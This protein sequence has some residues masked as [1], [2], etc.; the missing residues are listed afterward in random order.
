MCK[1]TRLILFFLINLCCTLEVFSAPEYF[2]QRVDYNI[3]V[4]LINDLNRLEGQQ[5]LT[6]FNHS[7]DTLDL[8]YFHLYL[9]K[10]KQKPPT[11]RQYG[12]QEIIHIMTSDEES[13]SYEIDRTIM[14]VGLISPLLPGDSV[15]IQIRFNALL[16]EASD[17]LGYYGDHFDI[18]NWYPVPAV[19]DCF[20]W[21]ADQH[22]DGEFYQEWGNYYVEITV[23]E[24]YIVG[25]TG[26]L[27]NKEVLPDSIDSEYREN[28]YGYNSD[29]AWVTYHFQ[30][31]NVHDFAWT[32]DPA[33]VYREIDVDGVMLKFL[34]LPYQLESWEPQIEIAAAAIRLFQEKI[35]PYPY[36]NMTVVD[37]YITAGGIEYP[38]FVII[39][40]V[41]S[42]ST[43]LS[44]T[45]IHEIA[46]QWFYGILGNNQTSYGWMDEGFAT[47]FEN[48]AM[49]ELNLYKN[50]YQ[51]SPPG[52]WGRFFGYHYNGERT[53]RLIYLRYIR[54]GQEEPINRHFDWFQNDP[55]VPF[56]QKMGLVASQLQLVLGDTIFW[57]GMNNYYENWKFR[58]P[59]PQDLIKSFEVSSQRELSWFFDQWVNTTWHCDYAVLG[60]RGKWEQRDSTHNFHATLHFKRNDPIVMPIDFRVYLKDGT[61]QDHR[62]PVHAGTA[63]RQENI[64]NLLPWDFKESEY[65]VEMEFP[66]EISD[67]QIDPDNRLLDINPFNNSTR[68][69]PKIYWSFLDRQYLYPYDDGYSA[70]IFPFIF[71]N[72]IDGAQIGARTQGN[73]LYSDYQHRSRIMLG[74]KSFQPEID[75]WFEHPLYSMQKDIHLVANIYHMTGIIGTGGWLQR[76]STEDGRLS[77]IILGWQWRQYFKDVYPPFPV[78]KGDISYIEFGYQYG[79]W[80]SGFLPVGA[81]F[82]LEAESSFLGSDYAY[83]HWEAGGMA[84][85]PAFFHQ[86]FSLNFRTGGFSGSVPVQKAF[87]V[88]GSSSYDY[89]YNPFLRAQGTLPEMWWSRGNVFNPGGGNLR[90][91]A[92][93][94]EPAGQY[95]LSGQ[96]A[97]TMGNPL[98]LSLIYVPYLSDIIISSYTSWATSSDNWGKFSYYLGEAGFS[99]S[100]TRLPFL[101]NYF[102][103][104]QINLDFPLWVNQ[105]IS[106]VGF[107]FRWTISLDIRNFN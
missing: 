62:I 68:R 15:E 4:K 99:L 5:K 26:D 13:L 75:I 96:V 63:S 23:P 39:N 33:F 1:Y 41:I 16:P 28:I 84:R 60:Y 3:R 82:S 7:P 85:L 65:Y 76:E 17:R 52:F 58:H 12:Y 74:L 2:Q 45:I 102:D 93:E 80:A 44:A 34:I 67:I 72:Q 107:K 19:Y 53:D 69:I 104:D 24:G 8:L 81:E 40:D 73:Y 100:L 105:N 27:L 57:E 56:Y 25:A 21:H 51:L 31:V 54:S 22:Y 79:Y 64:E 91:L 30:A 10:F 71:Y 103:L 89:L 35:G 90:S 20:G 61:Q 77:R 38:Q 94:W 66:A 78:D 92:T 55:F 47:F 95:Y 101:L 48:L 32:A 88:G 14:R 49:K 97:I 83:T 36:K 42:D 11:S 50:A 9:N 37:G 106:D 87:R 18:G 43:D 29:N 86:K 59:Y 46:H 6:Y 70:S 98:N